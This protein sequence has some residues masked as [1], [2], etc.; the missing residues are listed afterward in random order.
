MHL[1]A[2]Y[3]TGPRA[4]FCNAPTGHTEAHAGCWQ[5]MHKRRLYRS[6]WVSTAVSLWA[7]IVSSAAI[8]SLYGS[9]QRSAHPPSQALQP[10]HRVLS[11]TTGPR[12][13][14]CNAPTGHTEAHAG[15]WQFM[16]KRRLYRS[17][18]V[19]TA[20][21]LWAEIVSSAAILSLYG[22]PQRSAQPLSQALQP[23]YRVLSYS[24][25]F[26][27]LRPSIPF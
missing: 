12:A 7:E 19:S 10:M 21:S 3:T 8:L 17:P 23:M 25:A 22:S 6:P 27:I 20:V 26:D 24:M 18:W 13:V 14:F 1:S 16:H 4:V 9:P 5:F 2:S 15:C 11:Y